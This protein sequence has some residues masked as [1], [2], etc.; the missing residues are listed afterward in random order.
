M[1]FVLDYVCASLVFGGVDCWEGEAGGRTRPYLIGRGRCVWFEV[2]IGLVL[3][4][5]VIVRVTS[6]NRHSKSQSF[7]T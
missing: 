4:K 7:H 3:V 1:V 2:E 6:S 5:V